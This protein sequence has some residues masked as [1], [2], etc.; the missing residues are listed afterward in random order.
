MCSKTLL[1]NLQRDDVQTRDYREMMTEAPT[2][3]TT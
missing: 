2:D 3:E 1:L